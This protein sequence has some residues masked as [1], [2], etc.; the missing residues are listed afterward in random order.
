M[1]YLDKLPSHAKD[2]KHGVQV[3]HAIQAMVNWNN[4][5]ITNEIGAQVLCDYHWVG[6]FKVKLYIPF[7]D[8]LCS[9]LNILLKRLVH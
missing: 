8:D 3:P 9:F 2:N 6:W 1:N 4:V 5:I 7:P